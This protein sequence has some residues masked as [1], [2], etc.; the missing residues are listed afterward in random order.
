MLVGLLALALAAC[1]G[2]P[3]GGQAGSSSGSPSSSTASGQAPPS[4]GPPGSTGSSVP[5]AGWVTYRNTFLKFELRHPAGWQVRDAIRLEGEQTVTLLP[6][7]GGGMSIAVRRVSSPPSSEPHEGNVY[8]G[9][10]TV[11]GLSGTRCLATIGH[12]VTTTLTG[13]DRWFRCLYSLRSPIPAATYDAVI[14]SIRPLP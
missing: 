14:A 1:G 12:T 2:Q 13:G 11:D 5:T 3:S 7:N 4:S 9:P 8:C 10:I 6:P